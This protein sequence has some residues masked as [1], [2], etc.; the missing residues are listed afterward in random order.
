MRKESLEN[1]TFTRCIKGDRKHQVTYLI[2]LSK[3]MYHWDRGFVKEQVLLKT[4]KEMM[5]YKVISSHVVKGRDSFERKR[6]IHSLG[7]KVHLMKMCLDLSLTLFQHL[8]NGWLFKNLLAKYR[9]KCHTGH[10]GTSLKDI[11][12]NIIINIFYLLITI[13]INY[14]RYIFVLCCY[15]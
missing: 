10:V 13:L 4:T 9:F 3:W 1:L 7:Y 12:I 14:L 6:E 5:L 2:S 8:E 11:V 15:I